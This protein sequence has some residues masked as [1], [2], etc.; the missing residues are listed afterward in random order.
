MICRFRF[1]LLTSSIFGS[2]SDASS[3][4][5]EPRNFAL[6]NK[7]DLGVFKTSSSVILFLISNSIFLSILLTCCSS[8]RL[9]RTSKITFSLACSSS[10]RKVNRLV[11]SSIYKKHVRSS[12]FVISSNDDQMPSCADDML[13]KMP[14]LSN[15]PLAFLGPLRL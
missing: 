4:F 7:D 9:F 6:D 13:R 1:F 11:S 3:T 14:G 2:F 10:C 5:K 15:L 8:K 12:S